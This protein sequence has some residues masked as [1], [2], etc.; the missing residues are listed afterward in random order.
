MEIT[1]RNLTGNGE[2]RNKGGKVQ[3]RRSMVSRHKADRRDKKMVWETEDS[4]N[5]HVLPM[6]VD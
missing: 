2:G 3:G 4:R 1:L 5:L 6:G